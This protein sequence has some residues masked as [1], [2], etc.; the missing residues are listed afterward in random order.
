MTEG[1]NR[2]MN[3]KTK[4]SD[5]EMK[6]ASEKL[7]AAKA[8]L[9][10]AENIWNDKDFLKVLET[11]PSKEILRAFQLKE[12]IG[13]KILEIENTQIAAVISKIEENSLALES[14][15]AD[16]TNALQTLSD[17]AKILNTIGSLLSVVGRILTL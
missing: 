15:T 6:K 10:N 1:G 14:A 2:P 8:E 13:T 17:V 3:E 5:E 7:I 9:Q 16:L 12:E 4:Q 11:K